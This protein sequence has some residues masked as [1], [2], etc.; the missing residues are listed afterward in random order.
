MARIDDYETAYRL[1]REEFINRDPHQ[2]A[3]GTGAKL[4]SEGHIQLVFLN[5]LIQVS[6][7]GG[8]VAVLDGG[9][10]VSIQGKV[11]ILHYLN[12]PQGRPP[13]GKLITFREVP[14]G[15]FYY[16][17][18]EKRAKVPL[19]STFGQTPEKLLNLAPVL[20][21]APVEHSGVAVQINVL[22][23]VPVTLVIWPGDEEFPPDGNVLFDENIT[24][25]FQAEDV[26]VIAGLAIYP[27]MGMARSG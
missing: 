10:D 11:I 5:R 12:A 8:E 21:G 18:F 24:S 13:K 3:A 22:P 7:P 4:T 15:E 9:P 27:L 20:G 19:L 17:A 6:A 16:S 14:A 25:F 23:Y 1:A 2:A 26:A